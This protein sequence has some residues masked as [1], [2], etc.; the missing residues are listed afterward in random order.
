MKE[1]KDIK[2]QIRITPTEK[3]LLAKL[4][5]INKELTISKLFRQA[6]HENCEKLGIKIEEIIAPTENIVENPVEV[7]QNPV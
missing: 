2:V 7:S 4:V 6:L 1:T 3:T 5:E